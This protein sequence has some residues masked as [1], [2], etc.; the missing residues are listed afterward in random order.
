M[1]DRINEKLILLKKWIKKTFIITKISI[2]Y[3]PLCIF[4][5]YWSCKCITNERNNQAEGNLWASQAFLLSCQSSNIDEFL[6]GYNGTSCDY[7]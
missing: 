6:Y 5:L 1:P 3:V 4:E 2:F 7:V